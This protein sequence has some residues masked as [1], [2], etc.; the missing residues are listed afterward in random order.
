MDEKTAFSAGLDGQVLNH[1]FNSGVPPIVLGNH[2]KPIKCV[3]YF[4]EKGKP[5]VRLIIT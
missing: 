4:M 3:E 2:Q 5:H 1:D